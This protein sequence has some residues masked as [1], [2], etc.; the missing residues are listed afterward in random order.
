[1]KHNYLLQ[2]YDNT[3]EEITFR[4]WFK[5]VDYREVMYQTEM[6]LKIDTTLKK[7]LHSK[8]DIILLSIEGGKSICRKMKWSNYAFLNSSLYFDGWTQF[9]NGKLVKAS[10][11]SKSRLNK[12][13]RFALGSFTLVFSISFI[14]ALVLLKVP[15]IMPPDD[16]NNSKIALGFFNVLL[17][18][19]LSGIAPAL[20]D[21]YNNIAKSKKDVFWHN[22]KLEVPF[23]FATASTIINFFDE[24]ISRS[25]TVIQLV[26]IVIAVGGIGTK[27]MFDFES[28]INK[29]YFKRTKKISYK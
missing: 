7:C 1:M 12:S 18:I 15:N 25:F 26:I 21:E 27:F 5:N 22:V 8:V 4:K 3:T 11:K 2:I 9:E 17:G 16:L 19:T 6:H 13:S 29:Y 28:D 20:R 14:F 10:E 24:D 23:W